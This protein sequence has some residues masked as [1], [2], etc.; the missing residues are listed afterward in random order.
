MPLIPSQFLSAF[1]PASDVIT[2]NG[3][4]SDDFP[5]YNITIM[6]SIKRYVTEK[7]K[8]K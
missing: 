6:S 7:Q 1:I 8:I 3:G 2:Y 5:I 4:R